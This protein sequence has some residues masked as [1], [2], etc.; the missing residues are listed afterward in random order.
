MPVFGVIV[1]PVPAIFL[2]IG[3]F[4]LVIGDGGGGGGDESD[5]DYNNSFKFSNCLLTC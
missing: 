5:S 2:V 4:I 3:H 1:L